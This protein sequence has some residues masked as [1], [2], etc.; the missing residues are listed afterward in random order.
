[1]PINKVY[2]L[3]TVIKSIKQYARKTK[4]LITFEYVVIK[5]FNDGE[6]DAHEAAELAKDVNGKI[7]LIPLS[8]FSGPETGYQIPSR[9][10][11]LRFKSY[12]EQDGVIATIRASKGSDISAACGQLRTNMFDQ[13][14]DKLL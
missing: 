1:M 12:I 6:S 3:E 7:N 5:E 8:P 13:S 4:R 9:S 11:M 10:D 2:P 14:G